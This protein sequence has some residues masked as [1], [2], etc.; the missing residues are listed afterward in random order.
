[1]DNPNTEKPT[2]VQRLMSPWVLGIVSMI[3]IGGAGALSA[4]VAVGIIKP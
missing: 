4:L 3:L 2:L 1:M